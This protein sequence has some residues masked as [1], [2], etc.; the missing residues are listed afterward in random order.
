MPI[1]S[2]QNAI[3]SILQGLPMPGGNYLLE[4]FITPP[5]PETD[6]T[7]P[8]AYLW[9]T[10]GKE[11]RNPG[12]GGAIPRNTGVGTPAGTK[13]IR[14]EFE[15]FLRWYANNDDVNADSWF[16]G[17]VDAV[18]WALRTCPDPQIAVDPYTEVESQLI[19]IGEQMSYHITIRATEDEAYN[20]YDA[21]ITLSVL[22][23][24]HA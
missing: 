12:D 5:D 6:Y 19:G 8:H 23:I 1:V 9:P 17:M 22:E 3:M 2:T 7:N 18:L 16:P 4:A 20:L 14:H 24:L 10:T 11:S 21:L 13:P 15:I